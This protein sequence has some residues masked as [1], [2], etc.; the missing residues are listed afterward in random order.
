MRPAEV[1]HRRLDRCHLHKSG[2]GMLNLS[3]GVVTAGKDWTNDGAVHEVHSLKRR[4]ATATRPVPI[5][6][7]FVRILR[8]HIDRF[9][10]APDGRLF[11]NQ[12]GN[13]VDAAAYGTTWARAR[14]QVRPDP[15]GARLLRSSF[16][17]TPSSWTA[18]REQANRLIEQSMAEWDR[19]SRGSVPEE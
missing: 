5:P 11:R 10:V 9:G 6:P 18:S 2:W 13:Y 3:G 7:Q 16:A 4:A 1:I 12:T 15:H 8:A 17:T 14:T 19:V